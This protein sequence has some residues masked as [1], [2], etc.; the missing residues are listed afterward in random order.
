[1]EY[2]LGV[3]GGGTKTTAVIAGTDGEVIAESISG[4][5][6]FPSVGVRKAIENLN[7]AIS[8]A[9]E[10][11]GTGSNMIFESSCFGFAGFNI[12]DDIKVYREIVGNDKLKKHLNQRQDPNI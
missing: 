3:D 8:G 11:T 10:N 6:S 7:R 4:A 1:M 9:I 2:I 12:P 5:S